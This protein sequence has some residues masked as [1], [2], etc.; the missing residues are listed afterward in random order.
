MGKNKDHISVYVF[1]NYLATIFVAFVSMNASIIS[2]YQCSLL[3]AVRRVLLYDI[4]TTLYFMLVWMVDYIVFEIS[5]ILYDMYKDRIK[6]T[7]SLIVCAVC[8]IAAFVIP[9]P[10]L[11]KYNFSLL[12]LLIIVRMVKQLIKDK[13][14]VIKRPNEWSILK[15]KDC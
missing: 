13:K 14:I 12:A 1:R 8:G 5:K 7:H 10:D 4:Y 2:F 6:Y 15:K 11:F 9:M 3:E